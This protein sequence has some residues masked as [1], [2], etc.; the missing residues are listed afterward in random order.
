MVFSLGVEYRSVKRDNFTAFSRN[1]HES[2]GPAVAAE[3]RRD[4]EGRLGDARRTACAPHAIGGEPAPAPA[5]GLARR[6]TGGTHD[7]LPATHPPRREIPA[8]HAAP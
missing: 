4:R 2:T 5:R 8:L 1:A 6:A 3:L 7:A